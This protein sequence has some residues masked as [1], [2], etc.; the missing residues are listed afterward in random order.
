MH[1]AHCQ[2]SRSYKGFPSKKHPVQD[3][4][5]KLYTLF[6]TQDSENDSLFGNSFQSIRPNKELPPGGGIQSLFSSWIKRT[7]VF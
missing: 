4:K 7:T 2:P 1:T 6:N 5:V 3:A